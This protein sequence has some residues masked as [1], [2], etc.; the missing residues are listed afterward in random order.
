NILDK[1]ITKEDG[2]SNILN[3][4]KGIYFVKEIKAPKGFKID[5]KIYRVE[6]KDQPV[7][8]EVVDEPKFDPIFLV[9][10]K[11][12][13][14]KGLEGAEF[15]VKYYP[16]ILTEDQLKSVK[17]EKTW[18]FKTDVNGGVSY[19]KSYKISG[20]DLFTVEGKEIG[21]IGTYTIRE[22][23][24]P[25]GYILDDTL[26]IAHIKDN[27]LNTPIGENGITYNTPEISN[28]P[29]KIIVEKREEGS[30]ELVLTS[31]A[32]FKVYLG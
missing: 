16:G 25:E 18:V 5:P 31:P 29:R 24:A 23:K 26:H 12:N 6:L 11:I 15:E 27:G 9:L 20:D 21:L 22:I 8:L 28:D 1:L 14:N 10:K 13:G 32:E 4:Q 2:L 30:E 7:L 19:K 17:A 3:L